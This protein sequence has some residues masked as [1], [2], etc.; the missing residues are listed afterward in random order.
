MN[1]IPREKATSRKGA[2]ISR[3]KSKILTLSWRDSLAHIQHQTG[4][5]ASEEQVME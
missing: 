4:T 2:I 5:V 1:K 3:K